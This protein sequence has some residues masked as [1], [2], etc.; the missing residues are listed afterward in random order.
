MAFCSGFF[1]VFVSVNLDVAAERIMK[2]QRGSVEKYSSIEEAKLLKREQKLN[3]YAIRIFIIL[4]IW[5]FQII[6]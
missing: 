4:I 1:K 3:V 6:I 2:D 5:I